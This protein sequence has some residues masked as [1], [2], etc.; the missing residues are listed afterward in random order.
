M[1]PRIP[2]KHAS[3]RDRASDVLN[4]ATSA[5]RLFRDNLPFAHRTYPRRGKDPREQLPPGEATYD[6]ATIRESPPVLPSRW[7][8]LSP[9]FVH[10]IRRL[11]KRNTGGN[12]SGKCRRSTYSRPSSGRARCSSE[13]TRRAASTPRSSPRRGPSRPRSPSCPT[14]SR[15]CA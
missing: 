11:T 3:R 4:S 5:R 8:V 12:Q 9:Q 1:G 13:R 14:P 2:S 6:A 7:L 15:S 10:D